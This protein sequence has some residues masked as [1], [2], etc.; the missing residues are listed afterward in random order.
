MNAIVATRTETEDY[1]V[2]RT[3]IGVYPITAPLVRIGG[4]ERAELLDRF[5]AKSAEFVEPDSVREVLSLNA[6]GSPFA[7]L[8][9]FEIGEESWL[10]PRTPVTA[11]Q[12]REYLEAQDVPADVTVKVEPEGWGA[13]AFEGPQAW[14]AAAEFVDFDISGV[15]LHSVTESTLAA[16]S[17]AL[18]Y[19][20]RVGTTGEYGYLLISNSPE[21][22]HEA[23]VAAVEARG[24]AQV[25]PEGLARVQAEAGMG[26]YQGGFAGLSVNEADLAWMIDWN[27]IGEFHGSDEL[28][29]PT[30]ETARLTA[31]A[32][33]AGSAFTAGAPVQ[34]GDVQVGTVLWQSPSANPDEEL[35]FALLDAPFWVPGLELAAEDADG[36]PRPL[37]TVTLPRVIARSLTVKIS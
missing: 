29:K 2:V 25:G 23:V 4:D 20:A 18:A 3:A 37:R 27:R 35:V 22:A 34:A 16:D 15:T 6:D 19:L 10:L 17:A 21:A 30:A 13:T 11:E 36:S 14:S 5:L 1:T 8:L 9:H 33:P 31:L 7:V 12:L 28:D 26:L 24:G 32:A